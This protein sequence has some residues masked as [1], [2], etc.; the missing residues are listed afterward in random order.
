VLSR[1]GRP[2]LIFDGSCGFCRRWVTRL[3]RWD[4]ADRIRLLPLQDPQAPALAGVPREQL[5]LAAHLVC[6]DGAVFRG[7]AA[8]RAL[9]AYLPGGRLVGLVF[10]LPGAM[11]IAERAY[12]WIARRWGP[13]GARPKAG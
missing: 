9:C 2:T 3:K 13:V 12:Q 11:P 7:A 1:D 6:P 10:R 4:R 8:A 5:E